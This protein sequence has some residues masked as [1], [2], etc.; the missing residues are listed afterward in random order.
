MSPLDILIA[1]LKLAIRIIG[2]CLVGTLLVGALWL[3]RRWGL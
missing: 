1:G 3:K 2:I